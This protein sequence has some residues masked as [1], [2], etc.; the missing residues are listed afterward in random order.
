MTYKY[1]Y[2][3]R[4]MYETNPADKL[5]SYRSLKDMVRLFKRPYWIMLGGMLLAILLLFGIIIKAPGSPLVFIPVLIILVISILS[6]IP[7]EKF[8]YNDSVRIG[9]IA[10]QMQ[11][12]EQYLEHIDA[13]FRK[14]GIDTTEKLKI[15]RAECEGLL[16]AREDK[17]TK[18]N[19]KIVDM[20]IGVPLGALIAS[21]IYAN[22]DTMPMAIGAL[23]L[24]GL[25]ILGG[26]KIFRSIN[27]Y[28]DGYF[29]DKYL[30]DAINEL[31]Y[32]N[33]TGKTESVR[34]TLLGGNYE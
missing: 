11:D 17:Y 31:E 10:Q 4:E 13:L 12:Y 25:I 23:I 30:L 1:R 8:F 24:I 16:K 2:I 18:I 21:I 29:K 14:Y 15:L 33:K 9:E 6:Q 34:N 27:Y 22:D 19:T 20:L 28:S 7:R 26:V 3:R 32:S 5:N